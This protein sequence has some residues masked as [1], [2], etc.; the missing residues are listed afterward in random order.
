MARRRRFF[1]PK[2]EYTWCNVVADGVTVPTATTTAADIVVGSDWDAASSVSF[3]KGGVLE[4]IQGKLSLTQLAV[5]SPTGGRIYM[6]VMLLN[7]AEALPNPASATVW[8][9]EDVL[10]HDVV[11][12]NSIH[13]SAVAQ[14]YPTPVQIHMDV[15]AKRRLD[16]NKTVTF[17]FRGTG[18]IVGQMSAVIRGL[19]KKP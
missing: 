11:A 19:V 13:N 9:E 1:G 18:S 7:V 12:F 4:R 2:A 6:A 17:L 10:W 14:N 5:A 16:T 8:N 15:K 3:V